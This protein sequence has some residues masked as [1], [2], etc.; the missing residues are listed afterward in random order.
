MNNWKHSNGFV[1]AE[2]MIMFKTITLEHLLTALVCI[3]AV[4]LIILN[5][6]LMIG[7]I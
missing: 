3:G 6:N 4:V 7:L 2:H 5:M 1:P